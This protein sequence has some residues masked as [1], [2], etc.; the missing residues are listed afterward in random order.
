M[1]RNNREKILY[2]ALHNGYSNYDDY[3]IITI[4]IKFKEATSGKHKFCKCKN[5]PQIV[6]SFFENWTCT[7]CL[8]P[9]EVDEYGIVIHKKPTK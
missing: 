1:L 2:W 7:Y 4:D 5:K 3:N 9:K 8:K 6:D